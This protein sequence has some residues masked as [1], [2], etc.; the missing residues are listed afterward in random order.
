MVKHIAMDKADFILVKDRIKMKILVRQT[1]RFHRDHRL[2]QKAGQR[3]ELELYLVAVRKECS[4]LNLAMMLAAQKDLHSQLELV[5]QAELSL[6]AIRKP[7]V[8]D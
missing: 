6:K 8:K 4:A 7:L 1:A 5:D 2:L 3:V